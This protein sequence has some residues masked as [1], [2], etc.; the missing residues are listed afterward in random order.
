MKR[1]T[2]Y[3]LTIFL[4][5][6]YVLNVCVPSASTLVDAIYTGR[7]LRLQP[8]GDL[9]AGPRLLLEGPRRAPRLSNHEPKRRR[10][11]PIFSERLRVF[12]TGNAEPAH[13]A[14]PGR[15]GHLFLPPLPHVEII[16]CSCIRWTYSSP[17]TAPSTWYIHAWY[18]LIEE[19]CLATCMP[20]VCRPLSALHLHVWGG[21]E[22]AQLGLGAWTWSQSMLEASYELTC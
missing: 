5:Y 12:S 10:R 2:E 7:V 4:P 9:Y 19:S 3:Y 15:G 22:A 16:L 20:A 21:K 1:C 8:S 14:Q 6:Q 11:I 13:H 17:S 18:D